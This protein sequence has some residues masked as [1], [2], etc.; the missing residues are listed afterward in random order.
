MKASGRFGPLRACDAERHGG[1]G[2]PSSGTERLSLGPLG[3]RGSGGGGIG[4]LTAPQASAPS[5]T[6]RQDSTRCRVNLDGR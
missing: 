2:A 6:D 4:R 5:W 3:V 1:V